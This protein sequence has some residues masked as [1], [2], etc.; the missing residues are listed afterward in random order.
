MSNELIKI[1]VVI[2]ISLVLVTTLRSRLGEYSLL[3]VFTVVC[4]VLLIVFDNLFASVTTLKNLFS[5]TGNTGPYFAVALK[6][7]GVSYL[8]SFSADICRDYGMSALAQSAETAGKV[9]IFAL[10]LPLVAAVLDSALRFAG[11]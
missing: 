11:Q 10:S 3:V 8:T 5:Q 6:A 7:L 9:M 4:A 2:L 1:L